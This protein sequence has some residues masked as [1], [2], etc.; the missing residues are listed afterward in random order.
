[1][2]QQEKWTANESGQMKQTEYS[3]DKIREMDGRSS[4]KVSE[5]ATNTAVN[6][7]NPMNKHNRLDERCKSFASNKL[8]LNSEL[9]LNN[10]RSSPN[11]SKTSALCKNDFKSRKVENRSSSSAN[12]VH[13][14]NRHSIDSRN[15]LKRKREDS[16]NYKDRKRITR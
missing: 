10:V 3:I 12:L 4:V 7:L 5:S 11:E 16:P 15:T 14:L 13:S 9:K 1:M 6:S 8:A 2:H